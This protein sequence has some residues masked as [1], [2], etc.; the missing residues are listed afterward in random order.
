MPT[1][2]SIEE[3]LTIDPPPDAPMAS[4]AAFIPR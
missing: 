2:P 3:M 4:A 1:M